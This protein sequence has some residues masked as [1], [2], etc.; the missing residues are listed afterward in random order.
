MTTTTYKTKYT[1]FY[2]DI[3]SSSKLFESW[4]YHEQYGIKTFLFGVMKKDYSRQDCIEMTEAVLE[5]SIENYK[6]DY[7]DE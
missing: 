1:G 4:L 3:V 5:T 2:V 6:E 7:M